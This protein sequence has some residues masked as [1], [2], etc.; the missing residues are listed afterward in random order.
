M[1]DWEVYTRSD[2]TKAR[3]YPKEVRTAALE[4]WMACRKYRLLASSAMNPICI[5]IRDG[6][7]VVKP[8]QVP[9]GTQ[10]LDVIRL[11]E[12]P[13]P[14]QGVSIRLPEDAL[15]TIPYDAPE[16]LVKEVKR[17]RKRLAEDSFR[18]PF[19]ADDAHDLRLGAELAQSCRDDDFKS[20][21]LCYYTES[22]SFSGVFDAAKECIEKEGVLFGYHFEIYTS[23]LEYGEPRTCADPHLLAVGPRSALMY[24]AKYVAKRLVQDC[25]YNV[26]IPFWSRHEEFDPCCGAARSIPNWLFLVQEESG[27]GG[28]VARDFDPTDLGDNNDDNNADN[29]PDLVAEESTE[30]KSQLVIEDPYALWPGF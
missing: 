7:V 2:G 1:A 22:P 12:L 16:T 10:S 17:R 27:G 11:L 24:S 19:T 14:S 23:P 15:P 3:R 28:G 4:L 8:K 20:M 5:S 18:W 26:Q 6:Q 29:L 13:L 9:Q 30:D 21:S 25:S